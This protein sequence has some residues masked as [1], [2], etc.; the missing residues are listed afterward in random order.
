MDQSCQPLGEHL[1]YS[2]TRTSNFQFSGQQVDGTGLVYLRAR[3]LEPAVGRFLSRDVWEGDPNQ[4]MSYNSWLYVR[5]SPTQLVDPSGRYWEDDRCRQSPSMQERWACQADIL[6]E[7]SSRRQ[8]PPFIHWGPAVDVHPA[9]ILGPLQNYLGETFLRGETVPPGTEQS[10]F[11]VGYNSCGIVSIAAILGLRERGISA[12]DLA[13]LIIDGGKWGSVVF[14]TGI[15]P[16][17]AEGLTA[18]QLITIVRR[19]APGWSATAYLSRAYYRSEEDARDYWF[20]RSPELLDVGETFNRLSA[21]LSQGGFPI[22]GVMANR[23]TGQ[24]GRAP[25][26]YHWVVVTG[27]SAER[28]RGE[29]WKWVRVYNPFPNT[30]EYYRWLPFHDNFMLDSD[31]ENREVVVLRH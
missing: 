29:P 26:T 3:Y 17:A 14:D 27:L 21:H 9:L 15:V 22:T 12:N 13:S 28:N 5:A 31:Q 10:Q 23:G 4:P 20:Q 16:S 1:A 19:I 18:R 24:I 6:E 7:W 30:A 25:V 8:E 11:A 2:G